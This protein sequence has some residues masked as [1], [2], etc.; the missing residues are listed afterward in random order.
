MRDVAPAD[1]AKLEY[2]GDNMQAVELKA[3]Y[4]PYGPLSRDTSPLSRRGASYSPLSRGPLAYKFSVKVV[5]KGLEV[6]LERILTIFTTI[7]FSSNRFHG[8]IPK[9]LGEL[10]SLLLLNLS[11]NSLSGQIPS[12]L[13]KLAELESL[14]L[15]TNKLEGRI[16]EQLTKLTFLSV[17]NLSHNELVGHIPEGKQFSTFSND[18]YVGNSGLCGLP[19][20]KKCEEP[21]PPSPQF[22]EED[23][24]TAIFEWKFALAGYGCGLVLGL[25][26]GYITFTVGK[27]WWVVKKVEKYQQKLV[28]SC[29]RSHKQRKIRKPN[30]R[31]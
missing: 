3:K 24:S 7:D 15:S 30:Q 25:S 23:D 22:D 29:N 20:T 5:M 8:E 18:S 31:S 13:G 17:L 27:P 26:M 2:I 6:E 11:H 1:K 21:R 14:D 16:P 9:E 19:L 10:N 28:G 12:S 4:I